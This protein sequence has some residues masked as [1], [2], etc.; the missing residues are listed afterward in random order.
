[1]YTKIPRF[2]TREQRFRVIKDLFQT[3]HLAYFNLNKLL[4]KFEKMDFT[5]DMFDLEDVI[6]PALLSSTSPSSDSMDM[7]LL[8]AVADEESIETLSGLWPPFPAET[9]FEPEPAVELSGSRLRPTDD[10][11]RNCSRNDI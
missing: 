11:L 6:D 7:P 4:S 3:K 8:V 5:S 1:M 10:S 2:S 9:E